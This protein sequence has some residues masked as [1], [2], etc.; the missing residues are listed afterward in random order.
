MSL[1][2]SQSI[3]K[4][5]QQAKTVNKES[6]QCNAQN[7]QKSQCEKKASFK[8]LTE[9]YLRWMVI[10]SNF[11]YYLLVMNKITRRFIVTLYARNTFAC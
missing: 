11:F 1:K 5:K 9:L 7:I 6:L 4:V 3:R 8:R 2:T 10:N